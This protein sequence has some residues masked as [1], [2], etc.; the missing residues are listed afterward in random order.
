MTVAV[1]AIFI[2]KSVGDGDAAQPES[3]CKEIYRVWTV[4]KSSWRV[5]ALWKLVGYVLLFGTVIPTFKDFEYYFQTNII[6]FSNFT[7]SMLQLL[8]A[9]MLFLSVLMYRGWLATSFEPRSI[10]CSSI[11]VN[12]AG[13]LMTLLFVLRVNEKLGISNIVWVMFSTT[14]TDIALLALYR[15]PTYVLFA[16]L[17]PAVIEGTTFAVITSATNL[18]TPVAKTFGLMINKAVGVTK[19]D[20]SSYW[21]LMLAQM[22]CAFIPLTFFCLIP[23]NKE[24]NETQE[25]LQKE[26]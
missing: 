7:F 8:G 26:E 12:I 16:K 11:L 4:I 19:D 3:F 9:T 1:F 17:T 20:M 21:V 23:L 2:D 10:V 5:T 18:I 13:T 14:V 25:Q 24:I 6:G 22:L 15:L